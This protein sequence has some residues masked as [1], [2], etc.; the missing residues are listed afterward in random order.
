SDSLSGKTRKMVPSATP[1]A[2]AICRVVTAVPC[3]RTSG[4]V[5]ARIAARRA[6]GAIR[7]ARREDG[8]TAP[9]VMSG[10]SLANSISPPA[11]V[12][13]PDVR[14][15][16]FLNLG[17]RKATSLTPGAEENPGRGRRVAPLRGTGPPGRWAG[18]HPELPGDPRRC[19][20]HRGASR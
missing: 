11:K 2:S 3:L 15:A 8:D 5:A 20:T 4:T 19:L 10:H 14:K 13:A 12:V 7:G 9:T 17:V 6:E 1:A 16:T 18:G